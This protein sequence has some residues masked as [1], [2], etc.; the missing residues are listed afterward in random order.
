MKHT[1]N[2]F[3][4]SAGLPAENRSFRTQHGK[5]IEMSTTPAAYIP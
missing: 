5:T 2:L 1:R 4:T 3:S